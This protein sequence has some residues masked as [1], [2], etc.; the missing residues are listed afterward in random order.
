MIVR[1]F[2]DHRIFGLYLNLG[3]S[4]SS[5]FLDNRK[6][7]LHNGQNAARTV[8]CTGHTIQN[9]HGKSIY[10]DFL[11]PSTTSATTVPEFARKFAQIR[12]LEENSHTGLR[13]LYLIK[14]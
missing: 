5:I 3:K 10:R 4:P 2:G 11:T 13:I 1:F 12:E 14:S 7:V 6:I 8:Y 9:Y